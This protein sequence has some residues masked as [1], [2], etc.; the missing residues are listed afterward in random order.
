MR[1][2][3]RVQIWVVD[4]RRMWTVGLALVVVAALAAQVLGVQDF[5]S[6]RI[7]IGS[8]AK[9]VINWTNEHFRRGVPVIGGTGSISDFMVRDVLDPIRG[10]LQSAAWWLVVACLRGGRLSQQGLAPWPCCALSRVYRYRGNEQLGSGN[11]HAESGAGGGRRSASA[12]LFRS[13]YGPVGRVGSRLHCGPSSTLRRFCR[14]S[15]T[16]CPSSSSSTSGARR[17]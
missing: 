3:H 11:G 6:W 2:G 15:S 16:W 4:R 7:G 10:V 8:S 13:E 17:V 5:P 14:S 9:S 1:R 12:S